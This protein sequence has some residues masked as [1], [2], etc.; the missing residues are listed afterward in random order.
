[1]GLGTGQ[2]QPD[3]PGVQN[4]EPGPLEA[5]CAAGSLPGPTGQGREG[6]LS[7]KEGPAQG[8]KGRGAWQ[9]GLLGCSC[10]SAVVGQDQ[11]S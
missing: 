6:E 4:E 5:G 8:L 7:G 9:A 1:M 3:R 2:L 10:C 11:P